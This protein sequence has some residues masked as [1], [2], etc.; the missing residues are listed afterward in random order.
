MG[1]IVL[2]WIEFSGCIKRLGQPE[3]GVG[4]C[5]KRC[6]ELVIGFSG[7][8][9]YMKQPETF[10]KP[11]T[12]GASAARRHFGK[13]ITLFNLLFDDEPSPLHLVFRLPLG[14]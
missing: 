14:D 12:D 4:L 2:W 6:L 7:C 9:G 1:W 8:L 3:N 5:G 10:A 13:S 11:A